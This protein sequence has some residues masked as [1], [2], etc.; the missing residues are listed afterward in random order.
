RH[1]FQY[2]PHGIL[3]NLLLIKLL[4]DLNLYHQNIILYLWLFV[5]LLVLISSLLYIHNHNLKIQS[6]IS[7]YFLLLTYLLFFFYYLYIFKK[8]AI[9]KINFEKALFKI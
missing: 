5:S 3:S 4:I 8:K 7:S 9:S 2:F 6:L 1:L